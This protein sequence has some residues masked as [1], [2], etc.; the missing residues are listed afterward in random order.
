MDG[1]TVALPDGERVR[2]VDLDTPEL[3]R[4]GA[5]QARLFAAAFLASGG[6]TLSPEQPGR[7]RYGRLLADV[8]VGEQSLTGA[9]LD[10]GLGWIYRSRDRSLLD[11]QALAVEHRRGVHAGLD[12]WRGGPVL[13][14]TN[15]FHS[16]RCPLVGS[17]PER[18]AL[19]AAPE[20]L[21]KRGLAPCRRCLPWPPLGWSVPSP[22]HR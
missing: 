4:P 18:L 16:P 20:Q 14:T 21:F 17:D 5:E 12:L 3:G 15:S 7:D 10:A 6:A 22:A 19:E 2:L 11:R 13:V 9:L 8:R 1:D